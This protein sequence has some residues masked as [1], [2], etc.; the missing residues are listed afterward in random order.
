LRGNC[1]IGREEAQKEQ[2][3]GTATKESSKTED[4]IMA[5][6]NHGEEKEDENEDEEDFKAAQT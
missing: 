1:R 3:S 2:R 6:Q 4:R 5:G